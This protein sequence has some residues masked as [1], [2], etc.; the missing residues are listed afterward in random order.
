MR[1]WSPANSYLRLLST[2]PQE[3][4]KQQTISTLSL[5]ELQLVLEQILKFDKHMKS[6]KGTLEC[7]GEIKLSLRSSEEMS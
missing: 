6:G 7:H 3:G 2:L 4:S 1:K 5:Q